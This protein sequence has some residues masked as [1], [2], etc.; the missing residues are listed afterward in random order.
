MSSRRKLQFAAAVAVTLSVL[1]PNISLAQQ[2]TSTEMKPASPET[3]L[4]Q[5]MKVL[6]GELMSIKS[7]SGSALSTIG[8][9][10]I[11]LDSISS[12]DPLRV[13]A[14]LT[15]FIITD[16]ARFGLS[17][18]ENVRLEVRRIGAA[19]NLTKV[20]EVNQYVGKHRV[21]DSDVTA[22]FTNA[23]RL[24]SLNGLIVPDYSPQ[25]DVTLALEKVLDALKGDPKAN[26]MGDLTDFQKTA[27]DLWSRKDGAAIEAG[28]SRQLGGAVWRAW[29]PEE[30]IWID[31]KSGAILRRD[32]Q[33]EQGPTRD[34]R[35]LVRDW[36]RA[37]DGRI[38][39][40]KEDSDS[41]RKR[42]ASCEA[43]EWFGDC[44]WHLKYQPFGEQ[45]GIARV[46][47]EDGAEL[48]VRRRCNA[49]HTP[50]FRDF[51]QGDYIREQTAYYS[52]YR[53]RHGL[54]T[55]MWDHVPPQRDENVDLH[56]DHDASFS[57]HDA[58]FSGS[59]LAY[60][61]SF[62]TSIHT[63]KSTTKQPILLHEYGHYVVWS[64]A[65]WYSLPGSKGISDFCE[66]GVD[67]GNALSETIANVVAGLGTIAFELLNS[68]GSHPHYKALVGLTNAPHPHTDAA[69]RLQLDVV[70]SGHKEAPHGRGKAFEQAIWELAFNLNCD[71]VSCTAPLLP[72]NSIWD[73]AT[74]QD[75]LRH[76]FTA[77][78]YALKVLGDNITHSQVAA[79]MVEKI[80]LD[81]GSQA[82]N[83][84][85]A[86]FIHH[87]IL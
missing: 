65:P 24:R 8:E 71:I 66:Q 54:K 42:R 41:R 57:G 12:N 16:R 7:P 74:D 6:P 43:D 49:E 61:S 67:E 63:R 40:L 21:L 69:S 39:S 5:E 48:E 72:G 64:Y 4:F 15:K 70:C 32:P 85:K 58:A 17:K 76:V 44:S 33:A 26:L 80:R 59:V 30:I 53:I 31:N 84:A 79:Q 56:I 25:A 50:N 62:Y 2:D 19:D 86:V 13:G 81:S 18:D 23:G 52:I 10:D 45:H 83:R 47:D 29:L 36:E 46:Q 73:G 38:S 75:V 3:P 27:S 1:H 37:P 22:V 35:L 28:W 11:G 51:T 9:F 14:A 34:C 78:G 68:N 20:A 87:G 55:L 60:F 82:A 77:L